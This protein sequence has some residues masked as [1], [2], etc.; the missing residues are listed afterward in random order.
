MVKYT[1]VHVPGHTVR[2]GKGW[3]CTVRLS[4]R[5]YP[6]QSAFWPDVFL[7]MGVPPRMDVFLPMGVLPRMDVFLPMGVLP[8]P[9][10]FH[11]PN[12][13]VSARPAFPIIEPDTFRHGERT[14]GPY[15]SGFRA[16][17]FQAAVNRG[18][19]FFRMITRHDAAH[20]GTYFPVLDFF[21]FRNILKHC[22][23]Y[24]VREE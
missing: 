6:V 15:G 4:V 21:H 14:Q 8:R 5:A 20:K 12:P 18:Y 3:L 23:R 24:Y 19:Y 13:Q 17:C 9:A 16:K 1:L 10:D 2:D 11:C 22:P 7:Y